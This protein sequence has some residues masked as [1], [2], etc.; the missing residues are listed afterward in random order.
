MAELVKTSRTLTVGREEHAEGIARLH[1]ASWRATYQTELSQAF[2]QHQDLAARAAE[3]RHHLDDGVAVLFEEDAGSIAGFVA[4]GPP[5]SVSGAEVEWEIYNLHVAAARHGEG[6]GSRLF[7]A[8]VCLGREH[9]ARQL[10]LWVVT[11]NVTARAFY[12][13]KGMHWDGGAQVHTLAPGEQLHEVRY[14]V[15]L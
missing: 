4:C 5:R 10:V 12:E 11:T 1:I 3:W 15:R 8:A 13:H 9:G 7:D 14:R 2:L 6:F